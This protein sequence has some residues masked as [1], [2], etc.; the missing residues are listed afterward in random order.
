MNKLW[1]RIRNVFT[2]ES[3]KQIDFLRAQLNENSRETKDLYICLGINLVKNPN[4]YRHVLKYP[5][6]KE[7]WHY[8]NGRMMKYPFPILAISESKFELNCDEL[9]GL[10]MV[11]VLDRFGYRC[12]ILENLLKEWK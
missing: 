11:A 7:L 1:N 3:D 5:D 12:E 8:N 2:G 9:T 6:M 4:Q 10:Y